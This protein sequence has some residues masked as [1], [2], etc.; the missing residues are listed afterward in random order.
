MLWLVSLYH[1]ARNLFSVRSNIPLGRH[2]IGVVAPSSTQ[3]TPNSV[4]F[5]CWLTPMERVIR[6]SLSVRLCSMLLQCAGL[7]CA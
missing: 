3:S 7:V 1:H 6:G 5:G 2:S 4:Y